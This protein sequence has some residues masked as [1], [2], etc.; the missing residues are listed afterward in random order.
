MLPRGDDKR[1]SHVSVRPMAPGDAPAMHEIHTACLT[2]TLVSHY[3]PEQIA[4]WRQG[5]AP[6]GYVRAAAGGERMFVAET[7][8]VVVGFAGWAGDEL[9]AL[10]VHPDAQNGGVGGRLFEA[11]LVDAAAQGAGI[12]RMKAARGAESFYARRGYVATGQGG[13]TKF[14]VVIEHTLMTAAPVAGS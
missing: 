13:V 6:E 2:R 7:Y 12:V 1:A 14:G 4:A 5:R 9:L 10:F 11:C 3:A 8:G